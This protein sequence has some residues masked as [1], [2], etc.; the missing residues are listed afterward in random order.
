MEVAKFLGVGNIQ[1]QYQDTHAKLLSPIAQPF[2]NVAWASSSTEQVRNDIKWLITWLHVHWHGYCLRQI[3]PFA[4]C[5]LS[6]KLRLFFK[7]KLGT[8][9]TCRAHSTALAI[10]RLAKRSGNKFDRSCALF[11]CLASNACI[12][13]KSCCRGKSSIMLAYSSSTSFFA[14]PSSNLAM[15]SGKWCC[16]RQRI[17]ASIQSSMP[18]S[19]RL[20]VRKPRFRH[21]RSCKI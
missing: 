19:N 7:N 2:M 9:A 16:P 15:M 17:S 8:L 12:C 18:L 1:R 20:K 6:Q 3:Q 5:N 21:I 4:S 11:L 13:L 10:P 14:T